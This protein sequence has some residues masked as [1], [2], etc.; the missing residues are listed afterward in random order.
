[1]GEIRLMSRAH[2]TVKVVNCQWLVRKPRQ[3]LHRRLRW[4]LRLYAALRLENIISLGSALRGWG[5][6]KSRLTDLHSVA[7]VGQDG[8]GETAPVCANTALD[9]VSCKRPQV[10]P[11]E[12]SNP[13]LS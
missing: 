4:A 5:T 1:M 6:A 11:I 7:S 10:H 9:I 3:E 2:I 13:A 12:R 8:S